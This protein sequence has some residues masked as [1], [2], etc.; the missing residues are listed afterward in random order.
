[1]L[2]HFIVFK[3]LVSYRFLLWLK[4]TGIAR[5]Y[6]WQK[7]GVEAFPNPFPRE[8]LILTEWKFR[9]SE[10]VTALRSASELASSVLDLRPS[11]KFADC[12]SAQEGRHVLHD[13]CSRSSISF[14]NWKWWNSWVLKYK[15]TLRNMQ[16]GKADYSEKS[17]SPANDLVFLDWL[18]F[19]N[20]SNL[21]V[22][23]L[24]WLFCLD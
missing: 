4:E 13:S 12:W 23:M 11:T 22:T 2:D 17:A 19:L 6:L 20:F 21:E 10:P 9:R 14:Q 15:N 8:L 1:M 16:C 5:R 3:L 7:E 24:C 18:A